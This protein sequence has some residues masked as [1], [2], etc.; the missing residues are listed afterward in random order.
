MQSELNKHKAMKQSLNWQTGI[1][2]ATRKGNIH[3]PYTPFF[4]KIIKACIC[5]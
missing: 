1:D 3:C 2:D 5:T 4:T